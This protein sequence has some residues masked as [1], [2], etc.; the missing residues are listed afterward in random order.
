MKSYERLL[1]AIE[2]GNFENF[3]TARKYEKMFTGR[4]ENTPENL[5]MAI[6]SML[7]VEEMISE[8][9]K[10][11]VIDSAMEALAEKLVVDG[12]FRVEEKKIES[13]DDLFGF[14]KDAINL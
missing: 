8:E 12:K 7:S 10:C 5:K 11:L 9:M 1:K 3:E 6:A 2:D 4:G 13:F 14:L